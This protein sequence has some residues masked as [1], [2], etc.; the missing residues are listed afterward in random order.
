MS[1]AKTIYLK[2]YQKPAYAIDSVTLDFYLTDTVCTVTNT[3]RLTQKDKEPLTLHGEDLTLERVELDG[4]VLAAERY[5]VTEDGLTIKDLPSAF[6]LTIVNTIEPAKNTQLSGLYRSSHMFCTQCEAQG[7]R[8][9]TYFLDRPDVLT[10]FTTRIEADKASYPVLLS[11]GN[12]IDRGDSEDGRHFVVWE[13]PF[14]K[15]A[16]LF[17]LVAGDLAHI[18]DHFTTMSGRKVTLQIFTEKKDIDKTAYAMESLKRA[19]RWDEEVYGREYDLDIFMIVAVSDFNMGAM[20]N[21]GLNIFNSSC[22]LADPKVSTD[23]N[24]LRIEG[25]VAH[26]YFHNWSGNRVTCRDWFQLSLKEGLTIFRDQEFSRDMNDRA[27]CR[28]EDVR[29]LRTMQFPEDAGPMAH[30]VRPE[31]FIEIN[32]FYTATVYNKGGEVIRM[33]HTLIGPDAYRRGTDHYFETFD[34]MAVTIED[35]AASMEQASG[36]DLTQFRRWYSQAGTPVVTA[37]G[38]YDEKAKTY[39]LTLS[40][41]TKPTPGQSTKEPFVIPVKMSL[42]TAAGEAVA[43]D[44]ASLVNKADDNKQAVLPL[45]DTEQTFVFNEVSEPVVPSLLQDFSAPVKLVTALCDDDWLLLAKCDRDLFNRYE[46]VARLATGHILTE[47]KN[48]AEGMEFAIPGT[49]IEAFDFLLQEADDNPG[50]VAQCLT[51]PSLN[52][53]ANSLEAIDID[54]L[55]RARRETLH[56][57]ALALQEKLKDTYQGITVATS[58]ELSPH[59]VGLRNLR[60]VLLTLLQYSEVDDKVA[61]ASKQYE[62]ATLMTQSLGALSSLTVNESEARTHCFEDF[63]RKWQDEDL[64]LEKWFMLQSSADHER[65]VEE[66]IRLS[67]H[68]AFTLKNPNKVRALL[69]NFAMNNVTHFHHANGQGYQFIADKVIELDKL[70]PQVAARMVS[71]FNQWRRFDDSRQALMKA[72]LKRIAGTNGLSN[73]VYEIVTKALS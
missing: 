18:E 9:I 30:P 47:A 66:V 58:F 50:F 26:E 5:E 38:Q 70:N 23:A 28:I 15:P 29:A 41:H 4:N 49:L 27:L 6:T 13:D 32:N 35:F 45:H 57:C 54:N 42:Y 53:L 52:D 64:V 56:A 40:Q 37:H 62:Q 21:K 31:S 25:I 7:F 67:Q 22:V 65:V 16:Y 2:D 44:C 1:D 17:A 3:M 72:E 73:D 8:R 68:P 60:N 19:M 69:I 61:L 14:N 24:F 10:S 33:M 36:Y 55:A 20:E 63:Y 39:T 48:I 11:N 71:S 59:A 43:L 51:L 12:C 34:G 46:S